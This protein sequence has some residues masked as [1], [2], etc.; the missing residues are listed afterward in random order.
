M[1]HMKVCNF[2][3][4]GLIIIWSLAIVNCDLGADTWLQTTF[5]PETGTFNNTSPANSDN[6]IILTSS[7]AI[8]VGTGSDGAITVAAAKNINTDTIAA[9]RTVADGWNSRVSALTANTATLVDAP[10]ANTFNVGDEVI[11]I[12]LKGISTASSNVGLYEFLRVQSVAGNILTFTTNKVNWY[13]DGANDTNVGTNQKVM[14]QRV[15]NYTDVTINSGGSLTCN[16]FNGTKGGILAFR[17]KGTVTVNVSNGISATGKGFVGGTGVAYTANAGGGESYNGT[18]GIGGP[19][20]GGGSPGQGGG[21]GGG[22]NNGS[23]FAGGGGA[24]GSGGGGG[25]GAGAGGGYI[26]RGGGGGGGG[27]GNNSFGM[28]GAGIN[29]GGNG[30]TTS[31]GAGAIAARSGSSDNGGGA[32]GGGYDGRADSSGLN[33]RAY[34]GGGGGAGGGATNLNN[35]GDAKTGANG[36]IGGG[37][38]II[39]ASF[40][41]ITTGASMTAN[42]N[43]GANG[44]SGTYGRGGGGGGGA[45][46]SIIILA[47]QII[48][49]G[50]ITADKGNGGTTTDGYTGGAGGNGRIYARYV[51][52]SGNNPTP[53]YY[54]LAI[55]YITPGSY[56]SPA[57]IP[58]G[59]SYWG[60]LKYSVT[61]PTN[62]ALTVDVISSSN[63][64]LLVANVPF[65]TDLKAAYPATFVNITGI[66]LRANFS[67]ADTTKTPSLSYWQLEYATGT[68][69]TTT[70]WTDLL[71]GK[72][73]QMGQSIAHVKFNMKTEAGI[74]KWRRFR[75]DKGVKTYTN[76]ACPDS[77]IEV[78]IWCEN[79]GN[80]FWDI[81]DTFISKGIF[82][83]GIC[84]LNMKGWE[85]TTTSKTYYIVYKLS[86]D[87]GGGQR[88]GVKITDSSYLEF[89]NATCVGVP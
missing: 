24:L 46:G 61:S 88:A 13:G 15:P 23:V 71:N 21:G 14:V 74:T 34:M 8:N 44:A 25:G 38:I 5:P 55:P 59:V 39:Y 16:A 65:G 3:F 20:N 75:V 80:G 6:D 17:A 9:G 52:F 37:I 76:I 69:V 11:L 56:I 10:P 51:S 84:Y 62:T 86:G 85:V 35:L 49:S 78:Q 67:A 36:G 4:W 12:S 7:V 42:G 81:G 1:R 79:T 30:T 70:N 41:N 2:G 54:S 87:V 18:G 89:E 57:L 26:A 27:H 50:N 22:D 58:T 45:G 28:G 82:G 63:N 77:K 73:I 72:S 60:V 32:G 31:G 47:T 66:K 43:N 53:N 48:N 33:T 40:I 29:S 64:S 19:Y 68:A 83:N